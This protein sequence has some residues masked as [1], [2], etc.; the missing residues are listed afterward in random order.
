MPTKTEA[1]KNFLTHS[2]QGDLALLYNA[3]ME[4]QVNVAQ[5]TGQRIEGEYLGRTWHGYTDGMTVW[6]A[7]RIPYKANSEPEYKD[8]TIQFPLD[9]HAEA[10]GMTGWDWLN[11]CSKWVA[12]DFD[13]I[14]GHSEK[15]TQKLTPEDMEKVRIAACGLEW[16]TVRKST[17]GRGLHLYV[18]LDDVET[19]NHNEHAALAR[20]I[21]GKMSA[22]TGFDF[23]SKVDVCGGNMWVWARKMKGT[24]GLSL[25]KQG[26]KLYDIP[27]NWRDHVK[28]VNG[29]RRKTLPQ[30]IE[31]SNSTDMFEQICSQTQHV[32]LDEDH[33]RLIEW[34]KTAN[35]V[36]WWDQD[37][38]MLV[39]HTGWLKQAHKALNLKGIF[40]TSSE[41][42]NLSEQN[43]FMH[44][45]RLGAWMVRRFGQ[46]VQEHE[47]WGQDSSGWTRCWFNKSADLA[48]AARAH[49][50]L[51]DPKGGYIFRTAEEA[52]S[53]ANELGV[54]IDV[55]PIYSQRETKIALHKDGRLVVAIERRENDNAGDLQGWL[56]KRSQ[57]LR[58]F[59]TRTPAAS[60]PETSNYDDLLRH[61]IAGSDDGGWVIKSDGTWRQEP[62]T[63]VMKAL[64]SHGVSAKDMNTVLGGAI[65]RPWKIVNKPFQSEYPGDREWNMR[66]AQLR[67]K[68]SEELPE[69][70][71]P[72]WSKI[73]RHCGE[74][75]DAAIKNHPWCAANG[76]ISG[77]DYLRCWIA[78][79]IKY[80]AEPLP[81]LFFYSEEQSTGKSIFHEALS[82]LF[83]R[84]YERAEAALVNPQGFNKEL[85]GQ[86]VCVV[87]EVDLRENK[88]AYNRIKDWV[89]ARDLLIHEKGST[90]YHVTNTT[91]WIQVANKHLFCPIFAGDTRITVCHV[92][93]LSVMEL[94]PKRTLIANLEKEA[95]N[96]LASLLALELP[97]S[98]DRL[99][100]PVIETEDKNLVQRSNRNALQMFIEDRCKIVPGQVTRFSD[101]Y[102]RFI[103]QCDPSE[104]GRWSKI[105]LGKELPTAVIKGRLRKDNH[106][107]IGNLVFNE[108]EYEPTEKRFRLDGEY[109][110]LV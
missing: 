83:S 43:C 95:P 32:P 37:N 44:V 34:L 109:L 97:P 74:G 48:T 64:T 24:D 4:C 73:L 12:F 6:K 38:H 21:L 107:Y 40:E 19:R 72:N 68:P 87:E 65:M 14:T 84:G 66:A 92:R 41:Q 91:H 110:E 102:D 36:W 78:S 26:T 80:P 25:I 15:H 23:K 94:I 99:N 13:A 42:K 2:T 85:E 18:F 10:I 106:F 9:L 30:T 105:R 63:H 8:T 5:D 35:A 88:Q 54:T 17:A 59:N 55:K 45:C 93:P 77:A 39:T 29:T 104:A 28:V 60:E 76:I 56:P 70:G 52:M 101:F 79:V 46:G 90:P 53:A 69:N 75:L 103:Q 7:F 33:K 51:E 16:V 100:I 49:G 82:L 31:E 22:L 62:L 108:A 1:I 27:P 47:S 81:Y 57:F 86:V 20:A 67:Y 50:G 89:T 96:F 71:C 61:L 98:T 58:I 3:N 11:R